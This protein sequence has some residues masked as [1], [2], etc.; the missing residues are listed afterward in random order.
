MNVGLNSVSSQPVL[1][2]EPSRC[3]WA[4]EISVGAIRSSVDILD[5][6]RAAT[7]T[8]CGVNHS[9]RYRTIT[10]IGKWEDIGKGLRCQRR[11]SSSVS[12]IAIGWDSVI[13]AWDGRRTGIATRKYDGRGS[14][15]IANRG[16]WRQHHRTRVA[17]GKNLQRP[18]VRTI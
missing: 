2:H 12:E 18:A 11:H 3:T 17:R 6:K 10:T 14:V 5:S 4:A 15:G 1:P 16:L 13:D 8:A 7:L 9:N